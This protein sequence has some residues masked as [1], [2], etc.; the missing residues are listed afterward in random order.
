MSEQIHKKKCFQDNK[1]P[2]CFKNF[3]SIDTY[4]LRFFLFDHLMFKKNILPGR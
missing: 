4:V 1:L 3:E 2:I